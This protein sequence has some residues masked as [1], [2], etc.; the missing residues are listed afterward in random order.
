MK[1]GYQGCNC[2]A[3]YI[4]VD[5]NHKPIFDVANHYREQMKANYNS[6]LYN[7]VGSAYMLTPKD[8]IDESEINR[9]AEAYSY[10]NQHDG[11]YIF[12]ASHA[13]FDNR[14]KCPCCS[15]YEIEVEDRY[16]LPTYPADTLDGEGCCSEHP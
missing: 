9:L 15:N 7:D 4:L 12:C 14:A 11:Y 6:D 5:Y 1:C 8:Y 3:K 2:E 10:I 16:M 13:F